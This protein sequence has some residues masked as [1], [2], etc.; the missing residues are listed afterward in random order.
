MDPKEIIAT[1]ARHY[2]ISIQRL[3][4]GERTAFL[5]RARHIAYFLVRHVGQRS[6]PETARA[7]N[8]RDHTT[9]M[10]EVRKIERLVVLDEQVLSEVEKIRRLLNSEIILTKSLVRTPGSGV[11]L[12]EAS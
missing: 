2:G 4:G 8:N 9:I 11:W 10:H 3:I 1:V 7:F 6:Y 12:E 5:I